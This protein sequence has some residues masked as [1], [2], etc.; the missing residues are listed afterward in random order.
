MSGKSYL[1]DYDDFYQKVRRGEVWFP[2]FSKYE[3]SP[4]IFYLPD[5]R[6]KDTLF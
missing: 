2:D 1:N 4:L 6:I 3:P 5:M